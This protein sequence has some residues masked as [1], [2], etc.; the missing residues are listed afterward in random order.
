MLKKN[1]LR[2]FMDKV[3]QII[4]PIQAICIYASVL[5]IFVTVAARELFKIG[6]T[7][8]YEVAC[9]FI[10]VLLFIGMPVNIHHDRNL[11][12]T[13]LFEVCPKPVQKALKLLHFVI[14]FAVLIMMAIGFKEYMGKLGYV[15]LAAS[16]FPNWLYYGAIGIGIGL[17]Q[18]GRAHV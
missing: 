18:I 5:M 9:F 7:W 10:I 12:V 4:F 16:K 6:I 8:G 15:K 17:S 13:A 11:K 2:V 14:I 3:E 1:Y